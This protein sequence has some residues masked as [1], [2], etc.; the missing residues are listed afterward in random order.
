MNLTGTGELSLV[1][2]YYYSIL[3]RAPDAAGKAFW[4]GEA[5]RLV[6][7]GANVNEVWYLMANYFFNS[8]E[9]ISFNRTDAQ[10][11]SDVYNTFFNRAPDPGGAAYWQSQ[12]NA[13]L[14]REGVIFWFMFSTEFST[15]TQGIFGAPVVRAEINMVMDFFRGILNRTPDTTA[16][17]FWVGQLRTAQCQGAGAVYAKAN[18]MSYSFL[19]TLPEY[20]ARNRTNTQFVSDMY[21]AFLR[22]GGAASEVNFWINQLNTGGMDRN[23]VRANF[24]NSPEFGGRV[25]GVISAGCLP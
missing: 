10:F 18:E 22:R 21:N 8:P 15:F 9:Y 20:P 2:H 14:S 17:N 4:E 6:G 24:I 7:L 1:S 5:T 19:F 25:N 16:F 23:T 11:L 13:G 12:I 3:N